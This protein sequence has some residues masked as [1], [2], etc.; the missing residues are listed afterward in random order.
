MR[1][2]RSA[3]ATCAFPVL[4]KHQIPLS[5]QLQPASSTCNN[6][7]L[8]LAMDAAARALEA[9]LALRDDERGADA[10]ALAA[11][12][13]LRP[14]LVAAAAGA[15]DGEDDED[16]DALT[17]HEGLLKASILEKVATEKRLRKLSEPFE[18]DSAEPGGAVAAGGGGGGDDHS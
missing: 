2:F 14:E 4:P 18:R 7:R 6:P 17:R 5:Q 13:L 3:G 9:E 10:R 1:A 16:D 11:A 8:G 15:G 12:H